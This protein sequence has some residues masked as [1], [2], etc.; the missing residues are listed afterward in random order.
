MKEVTGA[1]IATS[2][3]LVA[4]F[5]PV[6]FFPGHNRHSLPAVRADHRL[7]DRDFRLQRADPDARALRASAWPSANGEKNRF[8]KRVQSRDR[9]R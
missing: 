6:A 3:V 1:V 8:F 9:S 5:V 7:L 2:L 4:V